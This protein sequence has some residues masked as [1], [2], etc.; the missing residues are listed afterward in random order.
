[1]M[2]DDT[3]EVIEREKRNHHKNKTRENNDD[4]KR[5]ARISRQRVMESIQ[6][7]DDE[8]WRSY[9]DR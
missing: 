4:A 1:M 7:D 5:H 9:I 2:N 8:D 3:F 6:N